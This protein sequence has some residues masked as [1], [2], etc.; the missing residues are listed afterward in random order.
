MVSTASAAPITPCSPCEEE[1]PGEIFS[2]KYTRGVIDSGPLSFGLSALPTEVNAQFG[3]AAVIAT[4]VPGSINPQFQYQYGLAD[5]VGASVSFGD[6]T[7][8]TL[9]SFDLV[10]RNG[11]AMALSYEF[12]PTLSPT[13]SGIIIL[14]FPL[15]ITGT[16][17]ETGEAFAYTYSESTQS[18]RAVPIPA[19]L[20]LFGLGLAGLGWSRRKQA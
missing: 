11:V 13:T 10:I 12:S 15:S 6:A 1:D 19:T 7:W 3:L 14:N 8:S 16:V 5:V 4:P 9:A 20:A 2:V 17:T 18:I